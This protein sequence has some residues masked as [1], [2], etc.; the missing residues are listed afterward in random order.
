MPLLITD[1][2]FSKSDLGIL[3]SVFALTYGLSKFLSGILADR[4]NPRVFMSV[5]LIMTG[6]F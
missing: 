3:G 5:G 4:S 2:G 1:F 6:Y